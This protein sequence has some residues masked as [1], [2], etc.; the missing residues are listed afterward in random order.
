MARITLEFTEDQIKVLP[1]LNFKKL[2]V[3]RPEKKLSEVARQIYNI[4]DIW[5]LSDEIK[6]DFEFPIVELKKIS[7]LAKSLE[8]E[9]EDKYC[10]LDTY[11]FFNGTPYVEAIAMILGDY[12]KATIDG[13]KIEFPSEIVEK[14]NN[15]MIFI[16]DNIVNIENLIQQRSTKGGVTSGVKYYAYDYENIWYTEEEFKE[17]RKRK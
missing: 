5:N 1:W 7:N 2:E 6:D 13:E 9:D 16:N 15:I 12:D 11:D 17:R 8:K 4:I 10:G 14:I 3:V